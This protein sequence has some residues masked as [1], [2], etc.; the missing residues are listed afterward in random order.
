MKEL[1]TEQTARLRMAK[2]RADAEAKVLLQML[3]DDLQS[4]LHYNG[5]KRARQCYPEY[6]DA[7][8]VLSA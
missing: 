1:I 7:I 4:E 5:E 3:P 8:E 2:I 6:S